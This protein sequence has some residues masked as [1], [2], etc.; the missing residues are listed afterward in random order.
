MTIQESK[1]KS[2]KDVL[3]SVTRPTSHKDG[4]L[5][6]VLLQLPLELMDSNDFGA[7]TSYIRPRSEKEK[8]RIRRSAQITPKD[9]VVQTADVDI[10]AQK[11]NNTTV[12]NRYRVHS[13]GGY[14]YYD[15]DYADQTMTDQVD[16]HPAPSKP[17]EYMVHLFHM[18]AGTHIQMLQD[19]VVT[20]FTNLFYQDFEE[21]QGKGIIYT[22]AFKTLFT[23]NTVQPQHA[24][25]RLFVMMKA[26]DKKTDTGIRTNLQDADTCFNLSVTAYVNPSI[27]EHATKFP[28]NATNRYPDNQP[29]AKVLVAYKTFNISKSRWEG[30]EVTRDVRHWHKSALRIFEAQ[31]D[32]CQTLKKSN[33]F[34][35]TSKTDEPILGK[36]RTSDFFPLKVETGANSESSPILVV[37]SRQTVPGSM[38]HPQST[39]SRLRRETRTVARNLDLKQD[40]SKPERTI[41]E[42]VD[43]SLR[44]HDYSSTG[45]DTDE[46]KHSDIQTMSKKQYHEIG[47]YNK[48]VSSDLPDKVPDL[49]GINSL[50]DLAHILDL[51]EKSTTLER[52]HNQSETSLSPHSSISFGKKKTNKVRKTQE[53]QPEKNPKMLGFPN[54]SHYKL[55]KNSSSHDKKL[56]KEA[57]YI[58]SR[59][60]MK[61]LYRRHQDSVFN[62]TANV[63]RSKRSTRIK[64][65]RP[66]RKVNMTVD[67]T[68]IGLDKTILFP[69]DY[70]AYQCRGK[71]YVPISDYL[72]P[73]MH[74]IVQTLV[75]MT[76]RRRASRACCVPTKL[77]PI[78]IL[79]MNDD[80]STDF[81]YS[82]PDMVVSKCGC[83]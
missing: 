12:E 28:V 51:V 70:K 67:F 69:K 83:R 38:R 14:D 56:H 48:R 11:S 60:D 47:H 26:K 13:S 50:G 7:K 35:D 59:R 24:E 3:T 74:A 72:T 9:A 31:I 37:F 33:G 4:I 58:R 10:R 65:K 62:I 30:I 18:L 73:T 1:M 34:N 57:L 66:C 78:S 39:T 81:F 61:M 79:K 32:R 36:P 15:Y 44:K 41:N 43:S 54:L 45:A 17:P 22:L 82:Y 25:L 53:F 71:C 75:H 40:K 55:Q 20:S 27:K 2:R 77:D 52:K 46:W 68:Q 49:N 64:R 80:G 23:A 76:S 63:I 29:P 21:S 5:S 16:L 19:T 42:S 8:N 6:Q